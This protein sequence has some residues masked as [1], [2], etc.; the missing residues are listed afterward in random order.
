MYS[1]TESR[2]DMTVTPMASLP[3]LSSLKF[4]YVL[5][6]SVAGNIRNSEWQYTHPRHLASGWEAQLCRPKAVLQ[7]SHL[8][9]L[10][11]VKLEDQSDQR[12]HVL[13]IAR[14]SAIT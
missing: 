2:I 4:T 10:V 11:N 3:L 6:P 5:P 14:I 1:P 7:T 12:R 8:L 13:A 9:A